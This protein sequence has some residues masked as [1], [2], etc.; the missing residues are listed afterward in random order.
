MSDAV[1]VVEI[2]GQQVE[3]LP[4]RTLMSVFKCRPG[5]NVIGDQTEQGATGVG[6]SAGSA[7]GGF[8]GGDG[9]TGGAGG[10]GTGG[11]GG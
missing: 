6:G 8:M 3:L 2:N 1:S 7:V 9:G 10:T 5:V 11:I 4:A